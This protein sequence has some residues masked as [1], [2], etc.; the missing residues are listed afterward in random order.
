MLIHFPAALFP[1]ELAFYFV[2]YQTGDTSFAD[3]S[4][5]MIGVGVAGGWLSIITGAID[6]IMIKDA[7]KIMIKDAGKLQTKA[8]IH[9]TV[10]ATVVLAYSLI[11]LVLNTTKIFNYSFPPPHFGTTFPLE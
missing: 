10:N 11:A 9:G 2:S 3:P 8:L 5:L 7:G 6:L 1:V 4:F